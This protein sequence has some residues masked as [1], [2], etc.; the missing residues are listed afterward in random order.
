MPLLRDLRMAIQLPPGSLRYF[1][2]AAL[3]L[4]LARLR[5]GSDHSHHLR[6][7]GRSATASGPSLTRDQMLLVDQVAFAIP[8]VADRLPWRTDCLVQALAAERWLSRN[9]VTT[10]LVIGARKERE[11]RLDAHAW[12]EA[13]DR[14]VTGG[15]VGGFAPFAK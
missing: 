14:I 15:D 10:H 2:L 9:G 7:S 4:A 6:P 13:G 8:R 5:L 3:E 12:L 1:G 11:A